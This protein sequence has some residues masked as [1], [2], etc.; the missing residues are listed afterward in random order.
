L[1]PIMPWKAFANLTDADVIAGYLLSLAPVSN[2]VPGPFGPER[3]AVVV[4]DEGCAAAGQM[5]SARCIRS[6][7]D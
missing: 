1:A 3:D 7:P 4:R 5:R 2:K 6:Y